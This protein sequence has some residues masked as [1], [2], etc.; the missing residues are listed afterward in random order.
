[1]ILVSISLAM[2]RFP[3]P[4]CHS[5]DDHVC[6]KRAEAISFLASY[7]VFIDQPPELGIQNAADKLDIA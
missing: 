5:S 2:K 1:M 4:D 7:N 6:E 3:Q